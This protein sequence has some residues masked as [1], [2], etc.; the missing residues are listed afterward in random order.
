MVKFAHNDAGLLAC[1]SLDGSL[2]ICQ[3]LEGQPHVVHTLRHH[4]AGV[5]GELLHRPMWD[6]V[7]PHQPQT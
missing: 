4:T 6:D 5:T 2:S 1:C 7:M 3:V